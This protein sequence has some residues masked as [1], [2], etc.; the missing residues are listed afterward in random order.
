M[1]KLTITGMLIGMF[2]LLITYAF[3]TTATAEQ[4]PGV[5]IGVK[6]WKIMTYL[7]KNDYDTPYPLPVKP[8]ANKG[9]SFD[10]YPYPDR[11][12]LIAVLPP[13][14]KK[15]NPGNFTGKTISAFIA[16]EATDGAT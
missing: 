14:N 12:V 16:I 10:F 2:A 3:T 8:I 13:S 1:K 5:D 9:V 7:P 11:D 6:A 15:S 4:I